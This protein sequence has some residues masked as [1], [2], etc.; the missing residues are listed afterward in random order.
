MLM[1]LKIQRLWGKYHLLILLEVRVVLILPTMIDGQGVGYVSVDLHSFI[2]FSSSFAI[3]LILTTPFLSTLPLLQ[4]R[5]GKKETSQ[6]RLCSPAFPLPSGD[7]FGVGEDGE[8]G[9]RRPMYIAFACSPVESSP[10]LAVVLPGFFVVEELRY[11]YPSVAVG[12]R[13]HRFLGISFSGLFS[14][15]LMVVPEPLA[16]GAD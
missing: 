8:R 12:R 11:V 15:L 10:A 9:L 4:L 1:K 14:S 2:D 5:K 13:W 3:S 7:C 6:V 16:A